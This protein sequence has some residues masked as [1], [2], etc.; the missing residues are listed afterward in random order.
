MN[1]KFAPAFPPQVAQDNFGRVFAPVPGLSKLE[2]FSLTL[3]PY[4]LHRSEDLDI[5]PFDVAIKA[6][7]LLI[8]K[9]DKIKPQD[10]VIEDN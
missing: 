9:L 8:E 1:T 2:Y 10:V 5:E 7:E 4:Y 3:L 6:A